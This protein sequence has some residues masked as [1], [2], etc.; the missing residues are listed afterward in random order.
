MASTNYE[1]EIKYGL[2][3]ITSV[4]SSE[5]EIRVPSKIDGKNVYQ[6]C[7]DAFKNLSCKEIT[8]PKSIG[9]IEDGAFSN[10]K[11]LR[12]INLPYIE[13]INHPFDMDMSK[14]FLNCSSYRNYNHFLVTFL[15][16]IYKFSKIDYVNRFRWK[17]LDEVTKTAEITSFI[18]DSEEVIFP[19]EIEGYKIVS[20]KGKIRED[21]SKV[22]LPKYLKIIP[23]QFL[24]N[25]LCQV[26]V[27]FPKD[28]KVIEEEAF[29]NTSLEDFTMPS[30][31]YHIK[32]R[33]FYIEA[34][35]P[36]GDI[37]FRH[38]SPFKILVDDEAFV[39]RNLF[40]DKNTLIDLHGVGIFKYAVIDKFYF[41]PVSSDSILDF[42]FYGAKISRIY[43]QENVKSIGKFAF[44]FCKLL[45]TKKINF[46][47]A[48]YLFQGCFSYFDADEFYIN[49]NM[50]LDMEVFSNSGIKKI[51][52]AKDYVY[53][54]I[55]WRCFFKTYELD[56]ITLPK[57]ITNINMEAFCLS[58]IYEINLSN[59]RKID[60]NAF[61][62]S[63]VSVV[64][65][66][67]LE[68]L[69]NGVFMDCGHLMF[70]DFYNS[71]LRDIPNLTFYG[72][73]SL[74]SVNISS[75]TKNI[76]TRAF[77]KTKDL[78]SFNFKNTINIDSEAFWGSGLEEINLKK[79]SFLGEGAF[80]NCLNL[81]KVN[82]GKYLD[83]LSINSFN[84]CTN[85][86][87]IN[88][89]NVQFFEKACLLDTALEEVNFSKKTIYIGEDILG[90]SVRN[91]HL[92][93]EVIDKKALYKATSL[94]YIYIH[95]L[96]EVPAIFTR[97]KNLKFIYFGDSCKKIDYG[98]IYDLAVRKVIIKNK[99]CEIL[100]KNFVKCDNLSF[101]YTD[102]IE[103]FEKYKK[104]KNNSISIRVSPS[105]FS[106]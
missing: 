33:A 1:Y 57:S 35:L 58:N 48:K 19:D 4:T 34:R 60:L 103:L 81:K 80:C 13:D 24:I 94:E 26:K 36:D 44:C 47:N 106:L 93:C 64:N 85:L 45:N 12:K 31:V 28:L 40:F 7:K 50:S 3:R 62:G 6:I 22:K 66:K 53:N 88:L 23:K 63:N 56:S 71:K 10:L 9:K 97:N 100:G 32:K 25:Q 8:L 5:R 17:I 67:N 21:V 41:Y 43:N 49:T 61:F 96:E 84:M 76:G 16:G 51:T 69:G 74:C 79:V 29:M 46:K 54:T 27:I 90:A 104:K 70:V 30:S 73:N 42:T 72:C 87:N 91:I 82:L 77:C 38:E 92:Y 83:R 52:F 65:L 20:L 15:H 98:V 2:V 55:P 105:S 95:D 99:D 37:K 102:N 78:A 68:E 86:K 59:V 11:N 89:E 101:L 14:V 39:N 18:V 75:Y